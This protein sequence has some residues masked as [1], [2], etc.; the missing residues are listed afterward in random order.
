MLLPFF[1]T[2]CFLQ[3]GQF[4]NEIWKVASQTFKNEA[5]VIFGKKTQPAPK[6]STLLSALTSPL[7]AKTMQLQFTVESGTARIDDLF[8]DP[9]LTR[10]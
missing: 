8:I 10:S 3:C 2:F 9:F 6:V 4:I 1:T 5:I 7:G